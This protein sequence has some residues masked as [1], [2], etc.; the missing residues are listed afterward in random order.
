MDWNLDDLR[1]M[2]GQQIALP[3][4]MPWAIEILRPNP[5]VEA[6]H[7]PGDLLEMVLTVDKAYW[8]AHVDQWQEV[9]HIADD[10]LSGFKYVSAALDNFKYGVW[11]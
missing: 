1:L 3:I 8:H 11:S 10:L 4:L 2:I 6:G 7:F 5:W 9:S